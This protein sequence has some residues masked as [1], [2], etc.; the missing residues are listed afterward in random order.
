[1]KTNIYSN[2]SNYTNY[3]YSSYIYF[4]IIIKIIFIILSIYSIILSKKT[5]KTTK[6]KT[7]KTKTTKT[8]LNDK[9]FKIIYW[10]ERMEFIFIISMAILLIFLFNPFYTINN[11]NYKKCEI[12]YQTRLLLFLFGI[13][14]VITSNW[15]LFFEPSQLFINIQTSI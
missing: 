14:L 2:Y 13:I 5:T 4:I 12:N 3:I 8:T 1:M 7:T 6:T 10:R 11:I 9:Y 15:K